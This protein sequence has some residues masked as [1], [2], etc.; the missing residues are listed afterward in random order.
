MRTMT[1]MMFAPL[2]LAACGQKAATVDASNSMTSTGDVTV[3]AN[4]VAD[5]STGNMGDAAAMP[6]ATPEFV[7]KAAMGDM[8]EI[9]SS[10]LALTQ[11]SSPAVKKFAQSMIDAHTATTKGLKA[12]IAKDKVTATPPAALDVEH[13]ADIDALTAAN[14]DAFDTLYK[15]QQTAAHEKALA[16]HS[17]YASGGT[18]VALKA[19]AA[20]TAPKVQMHLDMLKAM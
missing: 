10:K 13:K 5:A 4:D 6:V 17:G 9:A 2:A 19:F 18:D 1:M 7:T 11:A 14:G 3:P 16:L 12:A 20:D 8:Y 15:T